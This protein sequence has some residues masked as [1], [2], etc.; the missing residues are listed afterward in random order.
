MKVYPFVGS[1]PYLSGVN[2][3]DGGTD[4]LQS[5]AQQLIYEPF[6][7][8]LLGRD[9]L[10]VVSK[11]EH[12]ALV[13]KSKSLFQRS[14]AYQ[15]D[16]P[17]LG[18]TSTVLFANSGPAWEAQ[19]KR[20]NP[21]FKPSVFK[22]L[23]DEITRAT[24]AAE[25]TINQHAENGT[26]FDLKPI[27]QQITFQVI[28]KHLFGE[29]LPPHAESFMLDFYAKLMGDEFLLRI[30]G[31]GWYVIFDARNN[32]TL[33]YAAFHFGRLPL[34]SR[35]AFFR[36]RANTIAYLRQK[37]QSPP[38]A[39]SPPLIHSVDSGVDLEE[40]LADVLG[41]I[42]GMV[43]SCMLS[44]EYHRH[45]HCIFTKPALRPRPTLSAG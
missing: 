8:H 29:D 7:V 14:W 35:L 26:T 34:P 23:F 42:L 32:H 18:A 43:Y 11:P 1:V 17:V 4:G 20:L 28:Y 19:R 30:S 10:L 22:S 40:Q 24:M 3:D 12:C 9:H 37:L 44:V 25:T 27:L 31:F 6:V 33:F 36:A 38:Q 5:I 13:I 21:L 15:F 41:V 39:S 2:P 16:S 45:Y